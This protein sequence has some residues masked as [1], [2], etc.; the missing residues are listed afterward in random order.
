MKHLKHFSIF[1][2][3]GE[4]SKKVTEMV[5]FFD[6]EYGVEVDDNFDIN[7]LKLIKKAFKMFDKSFIKN[8]K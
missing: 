6:K 3:K 8:K 4:P 1:E 2:S 5:D 7:H